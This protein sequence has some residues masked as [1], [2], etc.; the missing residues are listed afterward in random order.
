MTAIAPPQ[1]TC[2]ALPAA[3]MPQQKCPEKSPPAEAGWPD[4]ALPTVAPCGEC[5]PC[6]GQTL[7]GFADSPAAAMRI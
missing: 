7:V 1:H 5:G 2:A 6:L 3:R 4:Q